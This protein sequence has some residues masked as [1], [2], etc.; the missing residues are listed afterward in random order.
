MLAD[1]RWDSSLLTVLARIYFEADLNQS[2]P[3]DPVVWGVYRSCCVWCS[4]VFK[5]A[6]YM[7]F[8]LEGRTSMEMS[9]CVCWFQNLSICHLM[10]KLQ[11]LSQKLPGV[12]AGSLKRDIFSSTGGMFQYDLCLVCSSGRIYNDKFMI[13]KVQ[14]NVKNPLP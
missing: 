7:C 11:N 8:R 6:V 4:V 5:F 3:D 12:C 14:W 10:L 9:V 1:C 13:W 2:M